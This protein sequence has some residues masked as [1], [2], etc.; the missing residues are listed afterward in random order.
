MFPKYQEDDIVIFEDSRN[1][2]IRHASNKDC[3]VMVSGN[4]IFKKVLITEDMIT[5]IAYNAG[6]YDIKTYSKDDFLI[7]QEKL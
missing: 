7:K 5:L 2:N 3:I 4:V 1:Y 6:A